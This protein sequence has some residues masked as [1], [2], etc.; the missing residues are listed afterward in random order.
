MILVILCANFWTAASAIASFVASV[1]AIAIARKCFDPKP[2]IDCSATND[3]PD[4]VCVDDKDNPVLS[5]KTDWFRLWIKNNG[6]SSAKDV[7]VFLINGWDGN[8]KSATETKNNNLKITPLPLKVANSQEDT[9]IIQTIPQDSGRYFD[10]IA[11][12][13]NTYVED[14]VECT[15]Q[16]IVPQTMGMWRGTSSDLKI[17]KYTFEIMVA[18]DNFK[19]KTFKITV[20]PDDI[21]QVKVGVLHK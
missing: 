2:K 16:C 18:G 11:V 5:K 6:K 8:G 9:C 10:F 12:V 13:N 20:R 7:Q 19:S 15:D 4:H 14:G 1:V 21:D 17:E 3:F